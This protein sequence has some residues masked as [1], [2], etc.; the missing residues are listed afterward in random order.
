MR[1]GDNSQGNIMRSTT[2]E[3]KGINLVFRRTVSWSWK[4][5]SHMVVPSSQLAL[6]SCWI[7]QL[8]SQ[9]KSFLA[10]SIGASWLPLA[11][12]LFSCSVTFQ[13]L[14]GI[15][16]STSQRYQNERSL[17]HYGT[18]LNYTVTFDRNCRR[19]LK[20]ALERRKR[21]SN[22][23]KFILSCVLIHHAQVSLN[24]ITIA[25]SRT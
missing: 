8:L 10:M 5:N 6:A 11:C 13:S 17:H 1:R 22:N 18:N 16:K 25:K 2:V 4:L 3:N 19:S 20:N 21:D 9:I 15:S 12:N 23:D 14:P 7:F 24:C